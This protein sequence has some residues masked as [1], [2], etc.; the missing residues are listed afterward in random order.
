MHIR[1]QVFLQASTAHHESAV[2]VSFGF[3]LRSWCVHHFLQ[4]IAAFEEAVSNMK[5]GGIRR[6]EVSLM[7]ESAVVPCPVCPGAWCICVNS[8]RIVSCAE[9]M[10]CAHANWYWDCISRSSVPFKLVEILSM[11][12]AGAMCT[13]AG[14][15]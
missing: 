2:V 14:W 15:W 5:V 4:A 7:N 10:N 6:V 1:H 9:N 8:I 3:A 11:K 13:P 12:V